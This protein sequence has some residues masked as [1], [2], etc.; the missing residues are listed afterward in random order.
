MSKSPSL[1]RPHEAKD[2]AIGTRE[3]AW[4]AWRSRREHDL[5]VPYGWLTLSGITWLAEEPSTVSG[6]PGRWWADADGAHV[7]I[8][9]PDPAGPELQRVLIDG[10]PAH[11]TSSADVPEG[12][13]LRWAEVDGVKVEL[14]VRGGR[15][16]LRLRGETSTQ[17]ERF[18]GVPAYRYDPAAVVE[19]RFTPVPEQV[20]PI[21]TARADLT[22]TAVVVVV[23]ELEFTWGDA[24]Q[25]LTVTR[26]GAGRVVEFRDPTNGTETASWRV[27]ALPEPD[28]DGHLVLDLNRALNM[29]FAF[30]DFGTCPAP[31]AGNTIS[32]P[33]H[34]GERKPR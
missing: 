24:P 6:L 10:V 3:D 12:G 11:G 29:P 25:R 17:L 21:A 13:S 4:R 1:T 27:I 31:V 14:I 26:A 23:G 15:Y 20:V 7:R 28:A 8:D 16:A 19:A 5:A 9:E 33:V 18:T 22:Q 32:A 34:A 30:S 2:H